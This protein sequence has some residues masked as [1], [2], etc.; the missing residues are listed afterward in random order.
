MAEIDRSRAYDEKGHQTEPR[1]SDRSKSEDQDPAPAQG[2]AVRPTL[3]P[4]T[5]HRPKSH[6]AEQQRGKETAK[7][8]SECHGIAARCL[9]CLKANNADG[10]IRL[11]EIK[12]PST[13]TLHVA[14][15]GEANVSH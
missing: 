5:R 14:T 11:T 10:H 8:V 15:I 7:H 6:G 9:I 3:H 13:P 12:A 4:C 1:H 2:A